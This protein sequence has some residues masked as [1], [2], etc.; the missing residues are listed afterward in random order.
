VRPAEDQFY[1]DRDGYLI[2]PFGHGWTV[3][4]HVEDVPDAELGR[5]LAAVLGQA[6]ATSGETSATSGETSATSG[7]TTAVSSG[8]PA[9]GR[10]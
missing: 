6:P 4:S 10:G 2:D 5:R 8:A 3:A 9:E 7:E 1:G